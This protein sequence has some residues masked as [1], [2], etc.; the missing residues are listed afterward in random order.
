MNRVAGRSTGNVSRGSITEERGERMVRSLMT[1]FCVYVRRDQ[2]KITIFVNRNGMLDEKIN[3]SCKSSNKFFPGFLFCPG[4]RNK[5][6][7]HPSVIP[8]P[9]PILV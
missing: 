1:S 8:I 7:D 2:R 5:V 6:P 3:K 4:R 9:S